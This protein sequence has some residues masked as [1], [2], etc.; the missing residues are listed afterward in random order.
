M[1][2]TDQGVR[3]IDQQALAHLATLVRVSTP[4]SAVLIC[5]MHKLMHSDHIDYY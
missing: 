5:A 2:S 4:R 1:V 3:F